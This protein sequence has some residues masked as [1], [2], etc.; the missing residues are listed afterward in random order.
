MFIMD[1]RQFFPGIITSQDPM[2]DKTLGTV[3]MIEVTAK[4]L[5]CAKDTLQDGRERRGREEKKE[6]EEKKLDRIWLM[7]SN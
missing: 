6:P 2:L 7:T 5:D 4:R 3:A 1:P